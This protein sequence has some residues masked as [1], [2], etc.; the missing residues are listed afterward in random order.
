MSVSKRMTAVAEVPGVASM[1]FAWRAEGLSETT[2]EHY[3]RW[4][5]RL[6][7]DLPNALQSTT[8]DELAM[9]LS[10]LSPTMASWALRAYRRWVH[11]AELPDVSVGLKRPKEPDTPQPT[12]TADLIDASLAAY[13]PTDDVPV[14]TVRAISVLSLLW[15]SGM[16][17]SEALR[18]TPADI[19]L[20]EGLVTIIK[21]KT[22][23][24]RVTVLDARASAWLN[25]WLAVRPSAPSNAPVFGVSKRTLQR[26]C[27]RLTGLAPHAMRRGW[28]VHS[29]RSGISQ[30][31]VQAV[32]GWSSGAMCQRYVRALSQELAIDEFRT[33]RAAAS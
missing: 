12:A 24:P 18:M 2:L 21:S 22:G 17:V 23:K 33:R 3:V 19:D 10:G 20:A 26:D 29:L 32:A 16:R 11:A 14:R 1:V 9:Y 25:R 15:S 5:T 30:V 27:L 6:E 8:K 4:L 13:G 7:H 28:A 31:S